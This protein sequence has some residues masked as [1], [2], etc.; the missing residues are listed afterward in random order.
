M[1]ITRRV[2]LDR[3]WEALDREPEDIKPVID[4]GA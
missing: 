4:I 3:W 2:P 1:L